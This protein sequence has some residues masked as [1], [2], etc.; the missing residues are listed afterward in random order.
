MRA[1]SFLVA[2]ASLLLAACGAESG[3]DPELSGDRDA[4]SDRS[5]RGGACGEPSSPED[6]E[7]P[8]R[9]ERPERGEDPSPK[10]WHPVGEAGWTCEKIEGETIGAE[11]TSLAVG[12]ATLWIDGWVEKDDSPNEWIGFYWTLADGPVSIRVKAGPEVFEALLEDES[13]AWHHPGGTGGPSAKAISNIVFC[14]LEE[15][16]DEEGSHEDEPEDPEDPEDD[17]DDE[18][19]LE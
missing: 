12:T 7:R 6:R 14:G 2:L 17:G 11:E 18:I 4:V 13:G 3:V 1:N 9:P 15:N 16:A 8:P 5:C 19:I 10:P